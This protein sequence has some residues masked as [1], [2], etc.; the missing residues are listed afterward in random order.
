M[1]RKQIQLAVAA[2]LIVLSAVPGFA[3]RRTVTVATAAPIFVSPNEHQ[4]PL[5]VA[6]EGSVLVLV[7]AAEDWTH[8]QWEDPQFGV[9]SG[10]IQT[11]FVRETP[12]LLSPPAEEPAAEQVAPAARQARAPRQMSAPHPTRLVPRSEQRGDV[13]FGYALMHDDGGT[14]PLGITGTDSWRVHSGSVDTDVLVE[15][16]YVHG[17]LDLLLVNEG[18]NLWSVMGGVRLSGGSRYGDSV[19]GFGQV[20]GGVVSLRG[21]IGAFSGD[22]QFG[23]GVQPG[24][25][26]EIPLTRQFAIRP[27]ADVLFWNVSGY[28]GHVFRFGVSAVFR[29][30]HGF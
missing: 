24:F 12:V 25:G 26:V 13:S 17:N 14:Y 30:F 29:L 9:R 28:D 7:D 22:T 20:V 10:Y 23:W 8:V 5:R 2:A 27:Q 1:S 3:Q 4:T 19:R 15:S 16:Q 6:R 18:V 21:T 11:R